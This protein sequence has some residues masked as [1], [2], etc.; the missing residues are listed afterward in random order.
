MSAAEL[1]VNLHRLIDG[2]SNELMLS[3]IYNLISQLNTRETGTLWNRLSEEERQELLL[4][5]LESEDEKNL[6]PHNTVK[7]KHKKWL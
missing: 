1:K 7:E 6:I 4:A 3:K 2:M 5:D